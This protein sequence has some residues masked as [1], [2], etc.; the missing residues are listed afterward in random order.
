MHIIKIH[1]E[2]LKEFIKYFF[3]IYEFTFW[4]PELSGIFFSCNKQRTDGFFLIGE[5]RGHVSCT[6][7]KFGTIFVEY[8][9]HLQKLCST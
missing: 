7:L 9:G 4:F 5:V 6:Y 8:M 2:M 1:Y 3:K